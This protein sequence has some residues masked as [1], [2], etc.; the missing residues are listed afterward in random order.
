M[1][2]LTERLAREAGEF[3]RRGGTALH[4]DQV[5]DRAGEIR[6]GRRLRATLVMAAVVVAVAAPAALL[7]THRDV[8]PEPTPAAPTK[9]DT[10]PVTLEGLDRGRNP[11]AGWMQGKVWHG[12]DGSEFTWSGGRVLAV[13]LA[14]DGTLV[15][16]YGDQG[17][18]AYL[19]PPVGSTAHQM[20]SWPMEGGFAVS[21]DGKEASFVAPDG[22][23]MVIEGGSAHP[24][25]R[26][27][28]GSGFDGVAVT[29]KTCLSPAASVCAVWV[30]TNGRSPASWVSTPEGVTPVQAAAPMW[31]LSDVLDDGTQAGMT[32]VSDSGSCS[33][34]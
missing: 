20:S 1:N 7:A 14:G 15:A 17:Q 8:S 31:L 3:E 21:A 25:P 10:S 16:S 23:P 29:G 24:L 13:A 11:S 6:R 34:V 4:L 12:P 18:R 5:L 26:V 22:T 27:P 2:D 30:R 9:V 19:V 28:E 32:D 33:R